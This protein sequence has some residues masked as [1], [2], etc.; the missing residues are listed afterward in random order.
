MPVAL[1]PDANCMRQLNYLTKY[2]ELLDT[3]FLFLKK[4][5]L[6]TCPT[7]NYNPP[8][9]LTDAVAL[10]LSYTAT[11]MAPPLSYATVNSLVAPPC[12]GL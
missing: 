1:L 5:P 3:V 7:S 6:S 10:Q 4:K 2:L 11:T 8:G 12:P 9:Q